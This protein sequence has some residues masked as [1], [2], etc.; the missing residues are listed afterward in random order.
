MKKNVSLV[1]SGGGARGTAHIGVIEE[2]VK[3]GFVIKSIAGTSM[4]SVV[5]AVYSLDNMEK[6]K[7]WLYS[8]D[9]LKV[10]KLID[11]SFSTQGLIKGD[12]LFKKMKEFIPEEVKIEDLKINYTATATDI[13]NDKEVVF[14]NGSVYN[15]VRAS[16]AIPTVF[17]P[18]K[19]ANGILVDGGVI[20]NIPI[21]N[22]K[23]TKDDIL[24]V[25]NVN[26]N[27]P[28]FQPAISKKSEIKKESI[29]QE[30]TKEFQDHLK[31]QEL[32]QKTDKMGYFS[33][34]DRTLTLLTAKLDKLTIE[35]Y[36]PDILINISRNSCGTFDFYKAEE[37][38]EIGR[39]MCI[40]S[41]NEYYIKQ[42]NGN[43][44][45]I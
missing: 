5:G 14:T 4:G 23:R 17:T 26:A 35:K 12:R 24:V 27:T 21:S 1:L 30:K 32:K 28:K 31:K 8:L 38:V 29:Y 18:V 3:Q 16:V 42:G 25:V 13:A 39:E 37:L 20:D 15:A 19:T 43:S 2:L 9:K 40:E 45:N 6:F 33:I 41:L 36:Q 7:K 11:F 22:V 44:E 10:F 34:I